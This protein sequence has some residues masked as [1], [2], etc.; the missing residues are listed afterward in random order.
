MN[1]HSI[2]TLLSK[3]TEEL[4]EI[5][6]AYEDRVED[7]EELYHLSTDEIDEMETIEEIIANRCGGP[8]SM[9]DL[10]ADQAW[11]RH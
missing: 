11:R 7:D 4:I 5:W 9:Y 2:E 3:S 10:A 6:R 8:A 1:R